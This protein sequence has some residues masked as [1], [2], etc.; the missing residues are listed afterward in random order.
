MT[1]DWANTRTV[2]ISRTLSVEM[3]AGPGWICLRVDR[4]LRLD[5]C[6]G[7]SAGEKLEARFDP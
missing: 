5:L 1:G 3:T 4:R 6:I 7:K 2:Q